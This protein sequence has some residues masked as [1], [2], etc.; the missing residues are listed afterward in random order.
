MQVTIK[1][2][3]GRSKKY[4]NKVFTFNNCK[5]CTIESYN[6]KLKEW[7]EQEGFV[8]T[9]EF[10]NR[11]YKGRIENDYQ[12]GWRCSLNGISNGGTIVFESIEIIE[13]N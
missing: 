5:K 3:E 11:I 2:I 9:F 10:N 7:V 6:F 8:F 13:I 4:N 12:F 1:V